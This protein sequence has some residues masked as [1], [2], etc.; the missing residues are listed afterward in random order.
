MVEVGDVVLVEVEVGERGQLREV[1]HAGEE[2]GAQRQRVE[3]VA[4][5][6]VGHLPQADV[7]EVDLLPMHGKQ[8]GEKVSRQWDRKEVGRR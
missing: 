4:L 1:V 5:R 2:V 6:E 7:G 3:A 8:W